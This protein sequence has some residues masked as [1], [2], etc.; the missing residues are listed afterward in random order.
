MNWT[1][2]RKFREH[3]QLGSTEPGEGGSSLQ[4]QGTSKNERLKRKQRLV[5]YLQ[6]K[7]GVWGG[8]GGSDVKSRSNEFI[9]SQAYLWVF[10]LNSLSLPLFQVPHS[11]CFAY[12]INWSMQFLTLPRV[13]NLSCW[14]P[15]TRA[16]KFF[17]KH[18]QIDSPPAMQFK[19]GF[20]ESLW[21]ARK[22]DFTWQS[23]NHLLGGHF[24]DRLN[25]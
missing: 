21:E 24:L 18:M 23:L 14:V 9:S 2:W 8:W 20:Q 1:Y 16:G 4:E 22:A 11:P 13:H 5:T 6:N 7:N 10:P 15:E 12:L 25:R 3:P 17:L 19:G